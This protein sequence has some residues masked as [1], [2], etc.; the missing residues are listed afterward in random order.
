M[1]G[2]PGSLAASPSVAGNA[3]QAVGDPHLRNI[4][5]ERFDLMQPGRHTLLHIPKGADAL[6]TLLQVEAEAR[7]SGSQCADMYFRE[8]NFTGVWVEARHEGAFQFRAGEDGDKRESMWTSF[9]EVD[10]KV[11]HGHTQQGIRYLN[12]YVRHLGRTGLVVGG[13]LGV[14]DHT[15][16]AT[17]SQNCART[18]LEYEQ[19]HP[20]SEV[21][22]AG[23]GACIASGPVV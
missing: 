16:A 7:V 4:N 21:A 15:A 11:A 14:D 9:G 19:N 5:G 12:F 23:Q 6:D 17:P 10:L 3:A 18:R 20:Y 2:S 13:L 22:R 8:L 1:D